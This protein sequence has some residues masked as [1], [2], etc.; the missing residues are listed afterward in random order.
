[1]TLKIRAFGGAVAEASSAPV[2]VFFWNKAL[3]SGEPPMG[4]SFSNYLLSI[5]REDVSL[6]G[7]GGGLIGVGTVVGISWTWVGGGWKM[8]GTSWTWV[9]GGWTGVV[10]RFSI[11]FFSITTECGTFKIYSASTFS[12]A[13]SFDVYLSIRRLD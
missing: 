12:E 7:V 13:E 9:G 11:Y 6:T 2:G 5:T 10:W 4:G 8:V 3:R 1:L